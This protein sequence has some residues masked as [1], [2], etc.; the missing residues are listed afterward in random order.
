MIKIFFRS[1]L[2][3][4][5]CNFINSVTESH[6]FNFTAFLKLL[7][8]L[9]KWNAFWYLMQTPDSVSFTVGGPIQNALYFIKVESEQERS[10]FS[11]R[12][13]F[14]LFSLKWHSLLYDLH[15]ECFQDACV[16]VYIKAFAIL[17]SL[18][19]WLRSVLCREKSLFK[20]KS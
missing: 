10:V 17:I 12:C 13:Y 6:S 19:H 20:R 4:E 7:I 16:L 11:R 14:D 8:S 9:K 5:C 18:H 1:S 3:K 15:Y 2:I